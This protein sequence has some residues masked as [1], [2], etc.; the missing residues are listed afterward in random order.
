MNKINSKTIKEI[1][2]KLKHNN[3]YKDYKKIFK[4]KQIQFLCTKISIIFESS[5]SEQDLFDIEILLLNNPTQN[6]FIILINELSKT[7]NENF[8]NLKW[9]CLAIYLWYTFQTSLFY[10]KKSKIICE[11]TFE[12]FK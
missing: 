4:N 10:N 12:N 8:I 1:K 7:F 11:Y 9:D 3:N 6:N 5:I 2:K